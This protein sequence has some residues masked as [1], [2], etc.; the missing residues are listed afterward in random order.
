[1]E[2]SNFDCGDLAVKMSRLLDDFEISLPFSRVE[3]TY[4]VQVKFC[5]LSLWSFVSVESRLVLWIFEFLLSGANP[6]SI[7]QN[8]LV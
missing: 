5:S 1:M 7:C 2:I 3:S 8:T 4:H 6:G